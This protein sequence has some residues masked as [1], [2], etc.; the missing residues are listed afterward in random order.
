MRRL[1]GFSVLVMALIFSTAHDVRAQQSHGTLIVDGVE[2]TYTLYVPPAYDGSEPW[3]VVVA[4]H[5]RGGD[6]SGF[7]YQLDLNRVAR[8]NAFIA[9]YPDGIENEW[10]YAQD[11]PEWIGP[12]T[13]DVGF[14]AAL[15]DAL[16]EDLSI[17]RQRVYAAGFSNGGFMAQ[18]L[19]CEV[20]DQYAAFAVISAGFYPGLDQWCAT[21]APVP[22]LFIHGTADVVVP[23]TG[24]VQGS[25]V[26]SMPVEDTVAYWA[27]HDG[28]SPDEVTHET[29]DSVEPDAVTSVIYFH[30]GGCD[31]DAEVVLYAV[32]GGGHN[33][34]GVRGRLTASVA[35]NVTMDLHA[36]EAIWAFFEP[37][38][39]E[40]SASGSA[41]RP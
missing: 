3:P 31:D 32:E 30:I 39:L 9:V 20:P 4:L 26:L 40:A 27:E 41:I 34:P 12:E 21:S 16:A 17:D 14:L 25:Y 15:V 36:G 7:A 18:R 19:A 11:T 5:G 10:S 33:L 1:I 37:H 28:C 2:R 6:G 23:W 24:T 35:G 29:L 8:E 38:T 22:I 13:D